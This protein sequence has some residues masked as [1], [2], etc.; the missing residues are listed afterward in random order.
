MPL[1]RSWRMEC[2]TRASH[3][4]SGRPEGGVEAV[5]CSAGPYAAADDEAE[6]TA[7]DSDDEVLRGGRAGCPRL[8]TSDCR[9]STS[10]RRIRAKAWRRAEET[11]CHACWTFAIE[12]RSVE[13]RFAVELPQGGRRRGGAARFTLPCA[14]DERR[15]E[16]VGFL[17]CAVTRQS[18]RCVRDL[19]CGR[20]DFFG[21]PVGPDG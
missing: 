11:G 16:S 15:D 13:S 9:G 4:C 8:A 19:M 10:G 2:S 5:P 20:S 14:G 3:L 21:I 18:T 6:E 12:V 7:D 17:L 1:L